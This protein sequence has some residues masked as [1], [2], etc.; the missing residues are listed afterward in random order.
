MTEPID[1]HARDMAGEALRTAD[2]AMTKIEGLEKTSADRWVQVQSAFDR[3]FKRQW[4]MML[5]ILSGMVTIIAGMAAVL[6]KTFG[7]LP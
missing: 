1:T 7:L 2:V 6:A 4:G 5:A 3:I